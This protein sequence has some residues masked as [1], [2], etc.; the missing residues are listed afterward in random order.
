RSHASAWNKTGNRNGDHGLLG[1][2]GGTMDG[3]RFDDLA[4]KAATGA[5]RRLVVKGLVA[6]F[7]ATVLRF[8]TPHHASAQNT[9]P[10]GGQ[11][12]ALGANSECSQAG[13][14]VVCSDNGISA[15]GAFNCCRNAGGA[16]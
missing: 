14:S 15:D 6:G 10:L 12:S 11:C 13:G 9:V 7:T 2:R 16:C 8:G 4:R 3:L 5:S 1:Q